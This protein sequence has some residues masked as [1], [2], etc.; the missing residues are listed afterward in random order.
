[1]DLSVM[2]LFL[3]KDNI[4]KHREYMDNLRCKH[5]VMEK[6]IPEIMGKKPCEIY[7]MRLKRSV[8]QEILPLLINY[9]SHMTFFDSF[10]KNDVRHPE[11][12]RYFSSED[13]FCYRAL[14]YAKGIEYGFLYVYKDRR[15]NIKFVSSEEPND[16]YAVTEPVLALDV[17]EHVYFADYGYRREEYLKAAIARLDIA[18]LLSEK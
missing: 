9:Y 17:C 7:R 12:K 13:D 15:G 5:S 2:E 10:S 14:E 8:K 11:I 18:K 6:S 4:L 3:S 1:M 16:I